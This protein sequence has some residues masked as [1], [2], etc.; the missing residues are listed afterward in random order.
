MGE[1]NLRLTNTL[2]FVDL[3]TPKQFEPYLR[4]FLFLL[5]GLADVLTCC[6]VKHFH[7][8]PEHTA[9]RHTQQGVAHFSPWK[10]DDPPRVCVPATQGL[11]AQSI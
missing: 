4:P 2:T 1:C 8:R 10:D 11:T 5:D 3:S 7:T 6:E 9:S